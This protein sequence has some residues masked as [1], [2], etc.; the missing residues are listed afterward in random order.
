MDHLSQ[1]FIDQDAG[2]A[3]ATNQKQIGCFDKWQRFLSDN[4]IEDEWLTDYSQEHKT[5]LISA[6]AGA[7]RR[8]LYGKTSKTQL[9]GKTVKATI[10]NVRSTFRSNL[11]PDP[12]LDPDKKMSLFLVRQLAGY[13]D[14][15]PSQKQ[16]KALPVSVFRKLLE[17]KF[18]PKD[19]ALGELA[20]GAFFFGMRSCEYLNVTG[21]RKTKQL[22][23]SEIRFFKNNIELQD[24][25]NP[26]IQFADTVSITFRFQKNKQKMI[27]VSQP[28]SGKLIC[29]VIIWAHIVLRVLSYK[30]ASKKTKVNAVKVGNKIT[31]IKKDEMLKHI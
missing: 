2:V 17:N 8:N 16:E 22:R 25:R 18:T 30:G 11:Q 28:R 5:Y 20:T 13:D 29:P 26:F 19:E 6:F 12:A 1:S 24:K 9:R 10:T 7:C 21:T 27:T 23:I 3:P 4:G 15:D 31:Y 14:A